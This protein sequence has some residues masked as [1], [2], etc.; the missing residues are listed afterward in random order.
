MSNKFTYGDG[1]V[2]IIPGPT[3]PPVEVR[4]VGWSNF[5]TKHDG[6][7]TRL[8]EIEFGRMSGLKFEPVANLVHGYCSLNNVER[9]SEGRKYTALKPLVLT[10]DLFTLGLSACVMQIQ[11]GTGLMIRPLQRMALDPTDPLF[12]IA[13]DPVLKCIG[14]VRNPDGQVVLQMR[15]EG[16]WNHNPVSVSGNRLFGAASYVGSDFRIL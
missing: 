14:A 13:G 2:T 3:F 12:T 5:P 16:V 7:A 6:S 8:A 4:P 11:I 10:A 9:F 15:Y 1:D